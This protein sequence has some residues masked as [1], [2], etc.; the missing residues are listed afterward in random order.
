[1]KYIGDGSLSYTQATVTIM[2][3]DRA[4]DPAAKDIEREKMNSLFH[5]NTGAV[6]EIQVSN[7]GVGGRR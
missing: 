5:D 3:N 2:N 6:G 4:T 7:A 1:M